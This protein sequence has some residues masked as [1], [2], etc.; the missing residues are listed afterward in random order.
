MNNSKLYIQPDWPAPANIHAATTLRTSGVS[1]GGAY[2]SL[3]LATHVGDALDL[4]QQNRAIVSAALQLPSEPFWLSQIHSNIAVE[5][6][7]C[8]Q[9]ELPKP[10][11][12]AS[13]TDQP[14]IV[15]AVMTADCLPVLVCSRDGKCVAAIHAGWR[16]L[17]AG[18]ITNTVKALNTTEFLVWLGPA[19]GPLQFEV[20]VE[21]RAAF[22]AK[23]PAYAAA[24][25]QKAEGKFLADIYK[26]ARIELAS[27]AV[28]DIYG[29]EFC[30]VTD[31][32]RFY[33]YRRDNV[34]GRMATLIWRD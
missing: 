8:L 24:F 19:I 10:K 6:Y 31:A 15:C 25:Q 23:S 1:Q 7:P 20:G 21:V 5:A 17:L 11:A 3:N 22:M 26:I 14:A 32:A 4:A 12:D 13:Y 33:S 27:L 30:T 34:T 28:I 18:V 2:A 29:G 16:G 9:N